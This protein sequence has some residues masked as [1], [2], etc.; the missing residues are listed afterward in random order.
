MS[1]PY[2]I[3]IPKRGFRGISLEKIRDDSYISDREVSNEV[4]SQTLNELLDD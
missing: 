1:F 3:H 2:L 4:E